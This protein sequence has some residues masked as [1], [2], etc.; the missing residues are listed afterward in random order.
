MK[1]DA[2]SQKSSTPPS[3]PCA[4]WVGRRLLEGPVVIA[5]RGILTV[6]SRTYG[7]GRSTASS[8]RTTLQNSPAARVTR[9]L[10]RRRMRAG[11]HATQLS[12]YPSD[13]RSATCAHPNLST[14]KSAWNVRSMLTWRADRRPESGEID[15]PLAGPGI[16]VVAST[17]LAIHRDYLKPLSHLQL[18][19]GLET[20]EW[21]RLGLPQLQQSLRAWSCSKGARRTGWRRMCWR[22]AAADSVLSADY[23]ADSPAW[24]RCVGPRTGEHLALRGRISRTPRFVPHFA[25]RRGAST[26]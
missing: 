2:V 18:R 1:S 26:G 24:K 23:P 15:G 7:S 21:F 16:A 12:P 22:C 14:Q 5:A 25:P 3:R 6:V 10:Q 9:V 8:T 20:K 11:P 19:P 4:G 17:N 13:A